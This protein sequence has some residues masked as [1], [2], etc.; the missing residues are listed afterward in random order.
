MAWRMRLSFKTGWSV[1]GRMK[2][3]S[4]GVMGMH[5]MPLQS[6]G[7]SAEPMSN[8][9]VFTPAA[10]VAASARE[11]STTSLIVGL[12]G[13]PYAP[14][15]GFFTERPLDPL[16]ELVRPG[17]DGLDGDH[18]GVLFHPARR[19]HLPLDC[20]PQGLDRVGLRRDHVNGGIVYLGHL[21][22]E[23]VLG[24]AGLAD[25]LVAQARDIGDCRVGI[26]GL[27]VVELYAF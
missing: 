1:F 23:R 15:A 19:F 17:A 11:T 20:K 6:S 9:V 12:G 10:R 2:T 22:D 24:N 21:L 5:L 13:P 26:P 18:L 25:D 14:S 4:L 16:L 8:S 7:V 27:A 3:V